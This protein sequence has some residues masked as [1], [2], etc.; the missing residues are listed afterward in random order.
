M[1]FNS[2]NLH[3]GW[4]VL[5]FNLLLLLPSSFALTHDGILLLSF[6]YSILSDPLSV[7][8]N[9]NYRDETP[10]SWN[11]VTCT[12]IGITMDNR[13]TS[14]VLPN[15]QLL[16]SI[17]E[18]VGMI[19]HLKIL[20]LSNN[21]LNGSLP[22][23][24]FSNSS[25][26]QVLSLANNVISG[27]IPESIGES[28]SLQL[29]NLSDNAFDG[30]VPK[31]LTNLKN[32]TFVSLRSNYFSGK[33]PSGVFDSVLLQTLDLSSN[34]FNGS[35]PEDF[36]GGG[37]KYLNFSYNKISGTIPPSFGKK[38]P[39][40]AIIDLSFN[41]L[42]GPIPISLA[43]LSQKTESFSGNPDL[44]GKPLKILCSIPSTLSNP[45]NS[46]TSPSS[47]S[48]PAIAA[49]PK[50]IDTTKNPNSS[51]THNN[52]PNGL[53]P[54]TIAGIVV[55]DLAGVGI[56]AI[57]ILL[58]YQQ[59]KQPHPETKNPKSSPIPCFFGSLKKTGE[60]SA[61]S[62]ST[63]SEGDD[64]EKKTRVEMKGKE[65]KLVTV[66]G[67]ETKMELE[68]LLRAT[69]YVVG[70]KGGSIVYRAVVEDG[71]EYAV[72]RIG[73][74]ECV[75]E[76]MKEFESHVRGIAKVR[77]RNL[78]R[79][80][81]FCWGEDEKLL[82]C[83]YVPNGSLASICHRRTG[84]SSSTSSSSPMNNMSLEIRVKIARGVARG[85]AF[86]H[87]KKHVHGNL[88]PSNILLSSDMEPLISD[89]GLRRLLLLTH[90]H[91]ANNSFRQSEDDAAGS[92]TH[93]YHSPYQAPEWFQHVKPTPKCDVYSYGVVLLE[94]LTGRRLDSDLELLFAGGGGGSDGGG[95]VAEERQRVMRMADVAI[96]CGC[97]VEERED[98]VWRCFELGF[99]CV[100]H[101]PHKR[102]SMK[103]VLH[104]LEKIPC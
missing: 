101:V 26:L 1:G 85:L 18:D 42:S 23:S 43:L 33:I 95:D 38:L 16:G 103:E 7:L 12:E 44:C 31:S 99:S 45:P 84:S 97:D 47:S 92:G 81:G 27:E 36:D 69:A 4:K 14:L 41:N 5:I 37:L 86:L 73:V 21:F 70:T 25:E 67:G 13:V 77:H 10:C 104:I 61:S 64:Q 60:S 29:L 17:S 96:R 32:L 11:G 24:I 59:R 76:R 56:L 83:D 74:G 102:P 98:V 51:G 68:T 62:E 88:K 87:D 94:L 58:V 82:I 72:R 40:N 20:D 22:N 49:I 48:S 35:L 9:W 65:G 100:S 52:P 46:T 75:V 28:K 93:R 78:V 91:T 79:V 89:F 19:Q 54:S 53:K 15:S 66:D 6:K 57:I 50:T 55:G 3:L 80:R 34:L 63:S 2:K 30:F 71:R 90:P 39:E 8:E